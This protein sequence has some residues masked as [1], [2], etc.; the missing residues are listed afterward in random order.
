MYIEK[1]PFY[2]NKSNNNTSGLNQNV[3]ETTEKIE[4]GEDKFS[5]CE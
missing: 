4:V 2:N 5:F 1:S 3:K